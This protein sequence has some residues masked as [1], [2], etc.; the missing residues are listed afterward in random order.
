M[1]NAVQKPDRLQ[2]PEV[3]AIPDAQI[4]MRTLVAITGRSRST[5]YALIARGEFPTQIRDGSRCSRWLASDVMKW[6]ET[7]S[8]PAA[9]SAEGK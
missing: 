1:S 5:L 9:K 8:Q 2:P 4:K 6:L 7:R 3:L